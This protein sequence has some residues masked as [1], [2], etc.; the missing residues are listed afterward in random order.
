MALQNAHAQNLNGRD[1]VGIWGAG[2][3]YRRKNIFERDGDDI[4]CRCVER[5]ILGYHRGIALG[6]IRFGIH[7]RDQISGNP[8][9]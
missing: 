4:F 8:Q 7:N 2:D 9:E 5:P 1:D 6:Q 3:W